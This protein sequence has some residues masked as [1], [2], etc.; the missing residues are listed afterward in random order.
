MVVKV[1]YWL[2]N[3]WLG[4]VWKKLSITPIIVYPFFLFYLFWHSSSQ[5]SSKPHTTSLEVW[6]NYTFWVTTAVNQTF[7]SFLVM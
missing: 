4:K 6:C 5:G 1:N 7:K 3:N 2:T